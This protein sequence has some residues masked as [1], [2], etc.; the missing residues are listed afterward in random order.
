MNEGAT[1]VYRATSTST[2]TS[3]AL[4]IFASVHRCLRASGAISPWESFTQ[5]SP[6]HH[7]VDDLVCKSESR[8]EA[9]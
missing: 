4:M 9:G 5:S 7:R 2:R 1:R 3:N 8:L 6:G